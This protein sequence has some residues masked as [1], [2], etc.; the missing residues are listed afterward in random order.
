MHKLLRLLRICKHL[1]RNRSRTEVRKFLGFS[2]TRDRKPKR[3]IAPKAT[4][5]FKE[6]VRELT[7][8]NQGVSL[9]ARVADLSAYLRGW[10]GYFG[11]CQTPWVLVRLDSWIRRRLRS[12]AWKQWKRFGRRVKE[13]QKR[14]VG[15]DWAVATASSGLGPWRLSHDRSICQALPNAFFETLGLPR[16]TAGSSLHPPNRRVRTRM[17]GGVGGVG[18]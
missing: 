15:R 9:E 4:A 7:R 16:L 17:H 3:R 10:R 1:N 5:R 2:F 8:R 11:F 12:V 13:L 14:G 18:G 6:R